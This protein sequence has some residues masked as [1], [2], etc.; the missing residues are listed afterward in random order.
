MGKGPK[1][2]LRFTTQAADYLPFLWEYF[3]YKKIP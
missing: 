3:I 1:G 2:K